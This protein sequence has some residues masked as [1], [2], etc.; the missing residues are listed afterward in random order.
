[1]THPI[2]LLCLNQLRHGDPSLTDL[3][4]NFF[5]TTCTCISSAFII[6]FIPCFG[7]VDDASSGHALK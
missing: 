4:L 7:E 1:M 2:F 3:H 5:L 6:A